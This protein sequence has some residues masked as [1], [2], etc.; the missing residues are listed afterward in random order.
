MSCGTVKL[1]KKREREEK[2]QVC[3]SKLNFSLFPSSLQSHKNV[4]IPYIRQSSFALAF[5]CIFSWLS[6]NPFRILPPIMPLLMCWAF[7]EYPLWTSSLS[8]WS[9]GSSSSELWLLSVHLPRTTISLKTDYDWL[10]LPSASSVMMLGIYWAWDTTS[11]DWKLG[12]SS[13]WVWFSP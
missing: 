4:K 5:L 3:L 6:P 11:G 10:I 7:I 13:G 1:K 9:Q 2:R 8:P 12:S